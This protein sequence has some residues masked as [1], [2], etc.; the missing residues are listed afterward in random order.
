MNRTVVFFKNFQ[1]ALTDL[2]PLVFHCQKN[3]KIDEKDKE[4]TEN[5]IQVDNNTFGY[6]GCESV[7]Q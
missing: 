2:F 4:K 5:R 6:C 7:R 1:V 3:T